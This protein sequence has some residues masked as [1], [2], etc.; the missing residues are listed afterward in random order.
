MKGSP[1][2]LEII[3][4][5]KGKNYKVFNNSQ[6]HDLNIVGIRT[7][8]IKA[9]TFNDWLTVFYFFEKQWNFFAFPGTT[10]PGT[11]WRQKSMNVKGT[12]VLKTGQYRSAYRIGKH[13]DKYKALRQQ[14]D[15]TVYRDA[16]R[17]NILDTEGMEEDTGIFG[18]NIHRSG[19]YSASTLVN[20]WSA[21]C[22]VFQDPDHFQFFLALCEKARSKFSN[23]F[24]YT[25]LKE[26][27]F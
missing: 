22:Q 21:G 12:A 27:D 14:G 23:S 26:E 15:V 9:N 8:S 3:D 10:D 20:K 16:N 17:D 24:T 4:V 11:Y 7:S 19:E 1:G 6:G 18:I 13:Q 2:V 5:M 25:L